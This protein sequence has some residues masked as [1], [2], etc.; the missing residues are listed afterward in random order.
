[1]PV[2]TA[3]G[4]LRSLAGSALRSYRASVQ[5]DPQAIA[6]R[7]WFRI[8]GDDTLRLEYP[9]TAESVVFDIG[10]FRGDWAMRILERYGATVHVFE[11]VPAFADMIA[12]RF[13]D[14]EKVFV[15]RFGLADR[16][17][18]R[19]IAVLSDRSSVY[20]R[21]SA[22]VMATF[23]DVASFL[24]RADVRRVDLMKINIEGG[25]YALLPRLLDTGL[26]RAIG[27]IQVQFHETH[28]DAAARRATIRERLAQTHELTYD[29]PFVWEN[30]RRRSDD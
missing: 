24:Q 6:L 18:T 12:A 19:P 1:M 16:D 30:W 27:D 9:L 11:P 14:V 7:E 3:L 13:R 4:R 29:F 23:C 15:H 20:R 26:T 8:R 5:R 22:A 25:E 17:E 28:P 21:G 10:G 2:N